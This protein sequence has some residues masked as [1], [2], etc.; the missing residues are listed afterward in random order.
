MNIAF[1]DYFT[2]RNASGNQLQMR[3]LFCI[4]H[5]DDDL[6]F[7][8]Y[9]AAMQ[10]KYAPFDNCP[11]V[12]DVF[13]IDAATQNPLYV[14]PEEEV[15]QVARSYYQRYQLAAFSLNTYSVLLQK[16]YGDAILPYLQELE[17]SLLREESDT[18]KIARALVCQF[19][20]KK[21]LLRNLRN[22]LRK[23]DKSEAMAQA[24]QTLIFTLWAQ[25]DGM[26]SAQRLLQ[27]IDIKFDLVKA[28][29]RLYRMQAS[30]NCHILLK[31]K[32]YI[33][34]TYWAQV[35]FAEH[36][37]SAIAAFFARADLIENLRALYGKTGLL[38]EEN[39][40]ALWF[41]PLWK[42]RYKNYRQL[43]CEEMEE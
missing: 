24:S 19:P 13:R 39:I 31:I 14:S 36:I 8:H 42:I 43:L 7:Q 17:I 34:D 16:Q 10:T 3:R 30:T 41:D 6:N 37:S 27:E 26:E 2:I 12:L 22:A 15:F 4:R 40:Q 25:I 29:E 11:D 23:L 28:L 33:Y 9:I 32:P 5:L 38:S 20:Q 21:R 35:C 1:P 18:E